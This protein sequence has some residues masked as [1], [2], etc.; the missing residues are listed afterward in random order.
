MV[1]FLE[2]ISKINITVYSMLFTGENVK[3]VKSMCHVEYANYLYD[4]KKIDRA[5]NHYNAAINL[6]SNNYYAYWGLTA[7]LM[8]GGLFTQA[9]EI[10]NKGIS[11]K[12]DARFFILQSA[13]YLALG[14]IE[15]AEDACQ[16]TFKHFH[17]KL[18]VAYDALAR[19]CYQ[20]NILDASE[21]YYKKAMA[22]NPNEAGIHYNLAGVYL[23]KHQNEMAKEEFRKVLELPTVNR[24]KEKQ[25]KK[26]AKNQIARL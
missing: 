1:R 15:Q 19:T 7:S 2:L 14:K 24:S 9:I 10:C 25:F 13:I 16:K 3:N 21:Y 5:I 20:F 11:I 12:P 18:D 22:I 26:Y 17:N 8:A 4:K 6:N 23:M